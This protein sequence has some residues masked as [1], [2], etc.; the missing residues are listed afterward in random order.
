MRLVAGIWLVSVGLRAFVVRVATAPRPGPSV[1]FFFNARVASTRLPL[2]PARS[3]RIL[4]RLSQFGSR[5]VVGHDAEKRGQRLRLAESSGFKKL[6]N[7][8]DLATQ[9]PP[10]DD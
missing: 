7:R 2:Q 5:D 6:R 1:L 8:V 3:S 4:G 9:V 10:G